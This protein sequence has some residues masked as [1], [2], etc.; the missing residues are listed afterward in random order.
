M[1]KPGSRKSWSCISIVLTKDGCRLTE[2]W[3]CMTSNGKFSYRF[4]DLSSVFGLSKIDSGLAERPPR[5][6]KQENTSAAS[7]FSRT[8]KAYLKSL[9][10]FPQHLSFSLFYNSLIALFAIITTTVGFLV[11]LA[12]LYLVHDIFGAFGSRYH[13]KR[14]QAGN[15][16]SGLVDS[17]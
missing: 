2:T 16:V 8:A 10:S 1:G 3:Y 15:S 9:L 13:D 5:S 17:E 7:I 12:L 11:V 6:C 4:L 14:R